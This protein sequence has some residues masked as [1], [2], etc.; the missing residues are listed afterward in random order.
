MAMSHGNASAIRK[1]SR[2]TRKEAARLR[3][4]AMSPAARDGAVLFASIET[5]GPNE[6]NQHGHRVNREAAGVREKVFA[7]RVADSENQCPRER[8]PHAARAAHRDDKHKKHQINNSKARRKA[9]QLNGEP[10]AKRGESAADRECQ[11]EKT[12]D[13][14]PDRLR[15]APVVDRAA[16]LGADIG[17]LEAVPERSNKSDPNNDQKDPVGRK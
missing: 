10:A 13:I 16:N 1:R 5:G 17:S 3:P 9:E 6:Q 4:A 14:D 7:G 2:R 12:V 11:R 8:S 15:H